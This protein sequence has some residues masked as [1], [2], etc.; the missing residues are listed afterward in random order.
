MQIVL[1]PQQRRAVDQ[2]AHRSLLLLG[3][4]GVGK[5]TAALHRVAALAGRAQSDGQSFRALVLAPTPGLVAKC[6][7]V[8]ARL[9]VEANVQPLG[10]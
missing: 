5:T 7:A 9:R 10:T 8:V 6:A 3:E 2:R 4:A 1:D